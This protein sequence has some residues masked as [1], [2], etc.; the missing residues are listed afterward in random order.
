M[1]DNPFSEEGSLWEGGVLLEASIQQ[2]L[3]ERPAHQHLADT[4]WACLPPPV[5]LLVTEFLRLLEL[6]LE[7]SGRVGMKEEGHLWNVGEGAVA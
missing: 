1:G 6:G 2:A 3:G 4:G 7:R 5:I